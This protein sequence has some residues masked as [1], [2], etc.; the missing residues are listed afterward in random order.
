MW[1][2][3]NK[4]GSLWASSCRRLIVFEI[5]ALIEQLSYQSFGFYAFC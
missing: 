4:K 2:T 5:P 1:K 3:F